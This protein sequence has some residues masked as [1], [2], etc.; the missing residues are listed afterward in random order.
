[1]GMDLLSPVGMAAGL[2]RYGKLAHLVHRLGLGFVETGTVTPLPEPGANRGIGVLLVNLERYGWEARD[3]RSAR[4]RLGMSIG[5]NSFTP[6]EQAWRDYGECLRRGWP[7][8]DYFTLNLGTA[9]DAFAGD[10]GGFANMLAKVRIEQLRIGGETGR[11]VPLAVKLRL[12]IET[13]EETLR[14]VASVA[15]AGFEAM[16]I[17]SAPDRGGHVPS[18][19]L[20]RKITV[21]AG[22]RMTIISVGEIRS[23]RDALARFGTGASLVQIHRGLLLR[24]ALA[25]AINRLI[26]SGPT[27]M[28]LQP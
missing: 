25:R 11:Q 16:V 4:A 23:P 7:Y 15:A 6:P 28:H 8:A 24:P 19:D 5:R 27:H 13:P 10:P 22:D 3:R 2:D 12:G 14:I 18:S 21:A 1:M 26:G 9:L 17:V 20:L